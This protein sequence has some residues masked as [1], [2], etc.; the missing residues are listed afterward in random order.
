MNVG[1]FALRSFVL[2]IAAACASASFSAC[3]A[4]AGGEA[5]EEPGTV[6]LPD[7]GEGLDDADTRDGCAEADACPPALDC[8]QADFCPTAFP[9]SR[10]VALNAIWGSGADDVWAVGTRGTVLHNDGTTFVPVDT[11][12]ATDIYVAVWGTS[13]GDVWILGPS[14]PLHSNGRLAD[15][16]AAVF[17]PREG[18]S[19]VPAKATTGRL[20]AGSS[21]GSHVW[22]AG[23]SSGRFG[24]TSS[25]WTLGTDADGAPIWQPEL[26]CSDAKPCAAAVRGLWAA[27]ENTAWAVG[28]D[29][30]AF[31]WDAAGTSDAGPAFWTAQ[32]SNTRDDL[33]AVWGSGPDDVWAVGRRGTIR[34][35][36]RGA[37]TWSVVQSPTT[38]DLHAVW[39]S[40]PN[41]VWAAGDSGTILHY[42]GAVWSLASLALPNGDTPTNL[43]GIWGS[44]PDDVWIVGEGLILHR[45]PTNRRR[46]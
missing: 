24:A 28:H 37:S 41:D 9:V 26:A 39:G 13:S 15:G 34:H 21:V 2:V 36:S 4:T 11:G 19:W 46:P 42:D 14:F 1:R 43:F 17:E 18:S 32:S 38:S 3:A 7:G 23:E 45:S 5:E 8:A 10:L 16:G 12:S 33:E 30:Q 25:F 20:W 44:G 31:V 35:T 27:G 6:T 40:G 22:L 29:G